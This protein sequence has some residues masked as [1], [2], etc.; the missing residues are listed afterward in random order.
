MTT[1][2]LDSTHGLVARSRHEEDVR[3]AAERRLAR[4]AQAPKRSLGLIW[5][6]FS[7]LALSDEPG[8]EP[9]SDPSPQ[10]AS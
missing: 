1:F 2:G 3:R 10:P 8:H 9:T 5:S 7:R 6:L 4:D